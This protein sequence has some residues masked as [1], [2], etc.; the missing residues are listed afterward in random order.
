MGVTEY[1]GDQAGVATGVVNL[2]HGGATT[3]T[4]NTEHATIVSGEAVRAG[5]IAIIGPG[6][7]DTV[8]ATGYTDV[9][10]GVDA[11]LARLT[12]DRKVMWR[13]RGSAGLNGSEASPPATSFSSWVRARKIVWAYRDDTRRKYFF[14]I[15]RYY[16][17]LYP[18]G[19]QNNPYTG[20]TDDLDAANDALIASLKASA[21]ADQAHP[22]YITRDMW[23]NA[24]YPLVSAMQ[25]KAVFVLDE[26]IAVPYNLAAAQKVEVYFKGYCTA[27]SISTDDPVNAGLWTIAMKSGST[28]TA[29]LTRTSVS[30]ANIPA[31]LNLQVTA[32]GVDTAGAAKT[33]VG[34]IRIVPGLASSGLTLPR[35]VTLPRDTHATSTSRRWPNM[36]SETPTVFAAG[37]KVAFVIRGLKVGED[38]TA[39]TLV[40]MGT[41]RLLVQRS[42]G[43]KMVF[44][45]QDAGGTDLMNWTSLVTNFTVAGGIY[46]VALSYDYNGGAPVA[47]MYVWNAGA[48]SS[49]KPATAFGA[50]VTN[51]GWAN[52]HVFLFSTGSAQTTFKGSFRD[53]WIDDRYIDFSTSANL[54]KFWNSTTGVPVDLGAQGQIDATQPKVYLPA[55]PAEILKGANWGSGAQFGFNDNWLLGF[56]TPTNKSDP[57]AY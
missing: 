46:N 45:V 51:I 47:H 16:A 43:N 35:G 18:N 55:E 2:G 53:I 20:A 37:P 57:Q 6:R 15:D 10:T 52:K 28:D 23:A 33:H 3:A 32:N 48:N 12:T 7:N 19:S 36:I 31:I 22:N 1:V 14:E 24:F 29:E 49:I 5:D 8:N 44:R 26:T 4:I 41:T 11:I 21:S 9:L 13:P 39:M 50:G 56:E 25:N 17:G 40:S 54:D 38:G 30:S 34:Y 42:S 27:C